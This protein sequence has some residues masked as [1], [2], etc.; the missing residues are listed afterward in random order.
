MTRRE[1]T[2][3]AIALKEALSYW[4]SGGDVHPPTKTVLKDAR[5][6]LRKLTKE[7]FGVYGRVK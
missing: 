1:K 3:A 6:L 7:L 4:T 5:A 2:V